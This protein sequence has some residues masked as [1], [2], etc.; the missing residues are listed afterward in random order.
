VTVRARAM[1]R[2]FKVLPRDVVR[3]GRR[4]RGEALRTQRNSIASSECV[5]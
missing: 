1:V 3:D 5:G 2:I 4:E